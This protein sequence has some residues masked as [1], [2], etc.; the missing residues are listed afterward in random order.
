MKYALLASTALVGAALVAGPAA[1]GPV[2]ASDTLDVSIRGLY[3]FQFQTLNDSNRAARVGAGHDADGPA[4]AADE[5]LQRE[6]GQVLENGHV[7]NPPCLAASPRRARTSALAGGWHRT[8]FQGDRVN[9][10]MPHQP[11][12]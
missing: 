10:A 3:V 6:P 12:A 7:G 9:F 5:L 8:V 2:N 11:E 1:A 4:G